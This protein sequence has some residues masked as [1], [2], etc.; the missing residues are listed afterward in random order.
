MPFDVETKELADRL[1]VD[2]LSVKYQRDA[3]A[4]FVITRV[5]DQESSQIMSYNHFSISSSLFSKFIFSSIWLI[6]SSDRSSIISNIE[7]AWFESMVFSFVVMPEHRRNASQTD[8]FH[9]SELSKMSLQYLNTSQ[10]PAG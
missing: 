4:F 1:K 9:F 8:Y 10:N 6:C 2:I 3:V 5:F 7:S